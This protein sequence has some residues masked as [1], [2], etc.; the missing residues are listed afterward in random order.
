MTT[1]TEQ[2]ADPELDL[3]AAAAPY[4]GDA[5]AE[6]AAGDFR[7]VVFTSPRTQMV[8]MTLN[9][10]Q[11]IG[12]EIHPGA[13]QLFMVASG[14]G[15]A[16]LNLEAHA[17]GPGSLVAVPAGTRHNVTAGEAGPLRLVTVYAP[18]QHPAGTVEHEHASITAQAL[19]LAG[20]GGD[21]DD[22]GPALD[23]PA[24][25]PDD[26]AAVSMY[27]AHRVDDAG[28][29]LAH[30][31][32]RLDAARKADGDLRAYHMGHCA[33]HLDGAHRSAHQLAA[34]LRGHYPS[35]GE[36]LD[37]LMGVVG[38]AVSVS[39]DAK[40]A[41][42][43]HLTQTICNHL[44]HTLRHVT[45]MGEDPDPDVWGFNAEHART[46]LDGALEHVGKLT[47]HLEDNYPA[48]AGFLAG[49]GSAVEDAEPEAGP[50]TI[51]E[52]A[53]LA[54]RGYDLNSRSG[55][56]SL[57]VPDGI[58]TP[59]PGGVTDF[60]I[61]VVYLGPDVD[62]EAFAQACH[63]AQKAAAAVPGPLTGM[64][65]GIG[66]FPP[67][68]GSDGKVPVWAGVLLPGAERLR[69]ALEDLS[70][71]EHKDWK[72]HVT[73]AYIDPGDPLPAPSPSMQASFSHLSVHRGD[74][75]VERFPLGGDPFA[76]G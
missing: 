16:T 20:D 18:P 54:N 1:I 40:T 46:H 60:H 71:S 59:V 26:K 15:T 5:A 69:G 72:P 7:R 63:R 68:D 14:T 39:K 36:E 41:T 51:S 49:L 24:A 34:N 57:D 8:V 38:L 52:Q 44:A 25:V 53:E 74:D 10:G 47:E 50:E 11:Q 64:I 28:K 37:A 19:A 12:S 9:P 70:A 73:L 58:I 61:T 48:E 75:E 56:I 33:H 76:A 62:D 31:S 66:T 30:A 17:V 32:E 43:A 35:E 67:S 4:T 3:A 6:T 23:G 45:A 27:T 65:G 22:E 2:A 21:P 29:H 13:D 55:M 42:T